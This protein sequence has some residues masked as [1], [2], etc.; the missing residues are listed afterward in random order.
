[1]NVFRI[2]I[3][4]KGGTADAATSFAYCLKNSLL[5]VGWQRN[6]SERCTKDWDEYVNDA[7]PKHGKLNVCTYIQKHV[8]ADDLVW[9]RDP[10]ANYYLARVTSGWEYWR[11][12]EARE[13]D[14]DIAN[15]FR[16]IIRKVDTEDIPGKVVA[17]FRP[18]IAF[19]I[20]KDSVS[21][22]YS[23]H[24]WNTL[25]NDQVYEINKSGFNDIFAILDDEET[26]DVIFIYAVQAKTGNAPI[27]VSKYHDD[28]GQTVFLFQS[29]GMYEGDDADHIVCLTKEELWS[30][31][32]Q[33]R[34]WLPGSIQ[35]KMRML[36]L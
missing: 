5:G 33:A 3:R 35:K 31:M 15:I 2:H 25:L 22:E 17:S 8:R 6:D 32:K 1:M 11:S 4:P 24:L 26:E 27:N 19:Q 18:P 10:D 13:K 14:I 21:L 36:G 9:T 16:C 23:K 7:L 30:F 20:I 12:P 29:N 28:P 34:E